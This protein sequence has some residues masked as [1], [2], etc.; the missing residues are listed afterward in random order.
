MEEI[1]NPSVFWLLG[2]QVDREIVTSGNRKSRNPELNQDCPSVET[3]GGDQ[4]S[5]GISHVGTLGIKRT[6][7]EAFQH[8]I[9][10]NLEMIEYRPS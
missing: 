9:S 7:C 2:F 4:E 1:K 3:H 10:R 5:V 8:L 6:G